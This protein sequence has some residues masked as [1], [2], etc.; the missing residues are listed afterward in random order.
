MPDASRRA[1]PPYIADMLTE[2]Q[3]KELVG[4]EGRGG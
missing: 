3:G 2:I 1:G 4:W